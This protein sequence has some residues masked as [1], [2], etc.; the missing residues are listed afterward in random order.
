MA[1]E[2]GISLTP[3]E[4]TG[5]CGRHRCCLIYEYDTY[6]ELRQKLPK[7]NKIVITAVGE[8]KVVDVNV[9][10]QTVVVEFPETGIRVIPLEE[11]KSIKE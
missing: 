10:A 9:L 7:K 4:I 11:I 3:T 6:T 2:Q 1:K 5:M 8:G